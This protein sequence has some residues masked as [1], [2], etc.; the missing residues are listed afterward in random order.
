MNK[1]VP[2]AVALDRRIDAYVSA[3][4]FRGDDGDR[5]PTDDERLLIFDAIHGFMVEVGA[6][7]PTHVAPPEWSQW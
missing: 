1:T 6:V 7:Q 4:C 3:Y 5:T 2:P